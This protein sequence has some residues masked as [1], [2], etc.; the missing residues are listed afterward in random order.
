MLRRSFFWALRLTGRTSTPSRRR[1]HA[2][3][4]VL[5]PPLEQRVLLSASLV[6]VDFG[7]AASASPTNWTLY[8]T[9]GDG[10]LNNLIDET[11]AATPIDLAID[12]ADDS[13]IVGGFVPVAG[14][15]PTHLQSLTG[16]NGSLFDTSQ[17]TLTFSALTPGTVY[18]VYVFGGDDSDNNQ[19]VSITGAN[20]VSFSQSYN[21]NELFINDEVGSS[22]RT[23][24]SYAEL[25]T[26][27]VT[28][29][30]QIV[31]DNMSTFFGLAG[32]GIRDAT[33]PQVTATQIN[34]G[35]VNRSGIG[36]L[37]FQFNQS[38][39]VAGVGSLNLF[40]H[41]TG[42]SVSVA[43]GMLQ[44]NG[45]QSITWDLTMV[46]L[47]NGRYTAELPAALVTNSWSVPL[48]TTHTI[49]FHKVAGDVDGTGATNFADFAAVGANFDPMAGTPYRPGDADGTG[50]VNFAD[51]ASV[52]GNF[53][54]VAPAALIYDLGDAPEA[55]T[56]FRTTLANAGAQHVITGN[57]LMLGAA[58]D[59]EA[60]GQPTA[61]ANGDDLAGAPDD[62]D[63]VT[64]GA[65][66]VGATGSVTINAS[67]AGVVNG[68][69]DFN[70][71]GDWADTGEQ[72]LKDQAVVAGNN[73]LMVTVPG[74]AT[75]GAR[76]TRIRLTQTG[77]YGPAGL[78]PNGEVEDGQVTVLAPP[79]PLLGDALPSAATTQ[80]SRTATS[81]LSLVSR[82]IV[83][84][85]TALPGSP[86][87]AQALPNTLGTAPIR[88]VLFRLGGDRWTG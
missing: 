65:L 31:V 10:T 81:R 15:L 6:G 19:S 51:F 75:T 11:G 68:W 76:T 13:A 50:A 29:T 54:P 27:S 8:S 49:E 85:A 41:T 80:D 2:P 70:N 82:G 28:G 35:S 86:S 34:S 43:G 42:S 38:V 37:N 78:A 59:S 71:D 4:S 48:L 74:S 72:V 1:R 66:T 88:P 32:V 47:P 55:G 87:G 84:G 64:F 61:A 18:E 3:V 17:L 16:I 44:N 9:P 57:T 46:S 39:T 79:A 24:Q 26:A 22:A 67:A 62:E 40:N 33:P 30:I 12:F 36:T 73:V 45:T 53:N 5:E 20:M 14:E 23:L 58:R 7:A 25:I 63:G 56:M 83:S 77:G 60:D 21:P 69:I 52:G